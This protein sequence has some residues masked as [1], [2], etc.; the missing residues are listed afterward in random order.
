MR[1]SM[2]GDVETLVRGRTRTRVYTD[3][4]GFEGDWM[5]ARDIMEYLDEKGV[6]FGVAETPQP[7]PHIPETL[8]PTAVVQEPPISPNKGTGSES[9]SS[10]SSISSRSP[11]LKAARP[12]F[13]GL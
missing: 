13:K 12:K 1:E 5:E 8:V 10:G 9:V 3:M 2:A 11:G 7:F 6:D 4:P